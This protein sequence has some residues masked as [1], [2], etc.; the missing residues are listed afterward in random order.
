MRHSFILTYWVLGDVRG[1]VCAGE[2]C[3]EFDV[4]AGCRFLAVSYLGCGV[5]EVDWEVLITSVPV[6]VSPNKKN[7]AAFTD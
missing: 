6:S 3:W 7:R 4:W 2:V 1:Y 5:F